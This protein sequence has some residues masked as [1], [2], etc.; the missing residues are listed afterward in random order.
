MGEIWHNSDGDGDG[1]DDDDDDDDDDG[2]R[3]ALSASDAHQAAYRCLLPNLSRNIT[4]SYEKKII[5]SS[6]FRQDPIHI[7]KKSWPPNESY[8]KMMIMNLKRP[9]DMQLQ[10]ENISYEKP[11][12]LWVTMNLRIMEMME[13]NKP[14]P[15]EVD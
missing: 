9:W 15:T 4:A 5:E 14:E 13:V 7:H 3:E 1:D 6:K 11:L 2:G 8:K 10:N 12:A